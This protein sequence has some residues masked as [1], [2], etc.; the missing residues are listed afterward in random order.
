[1]SK[2]VEVD[3]DQALAVS[4][5]LKSFSQPTRLLILCRLSKGPASVFEL[6]EACGLDQAPTS[7]FLARLRREGQVVGERSGNQ[8][9]Y[10]LTDPRAVELLQTL[11]RLYCGTEGKKAGKSGS[12]AKAKPKSKP[13]AR[14]K[15]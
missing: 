7:Q 1:M 13:T 15:V 6:Q 12:K 5:V 11:Y 14:N 9:F 3:R 2:G 10:S 8:I 4:Q